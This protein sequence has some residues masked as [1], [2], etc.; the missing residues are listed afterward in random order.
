MSRA[1]AALD[2]QGAAAAEK[3][4]ALSRAFC[5]HS[6]QSAQAQSKPFL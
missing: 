1:L 4:W 6:L 2:M 5:I 3:R